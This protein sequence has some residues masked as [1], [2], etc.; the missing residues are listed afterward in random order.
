MK[1]LMRLVERGHRSSRD[2]ER[3]LKTAAELLSERL[4]LRH[5]NVALFHDIV[6][7]TRQIAAT[8]ASRTS[9]PGENQN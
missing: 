5:Q 2:G 9:H 6:H 1:E 7:L 4:A 3:L 8:V